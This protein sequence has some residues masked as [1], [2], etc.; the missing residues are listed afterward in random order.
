MNGTTSKLFRGYR[1]VEDVVVRMKPL[2]EWHRLN[3]GDIHVM[4]L[5]RRDLDVLRRWPETA[6]HFEI[7]T[8][9]GVTYWHGFELRADRTPP[10]SRDR[11]ELPPPP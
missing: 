8:N 2:A 4:T 7:T 3:R 5:R 10:C 1:A 9:N 6:S 11:F